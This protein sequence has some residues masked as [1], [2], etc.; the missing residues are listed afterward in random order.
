MFTTCTLGKITRAG[1]GLSWTD[2]RD[3]G[4]R[5][6]RATFVRA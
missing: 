1:I 4:Q 6:A 2:M 3:R 5:R